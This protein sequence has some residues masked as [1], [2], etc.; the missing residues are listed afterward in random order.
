MS[1]KTW[2]LFVFSMILLAFVLFGQLMDRP[3]PGIASRDW[4][5]DRD[6]GSQAVGAKPEG[7]SKVL[8]VAVSMSSTEF[9]ALQK[10]N[11]SYEKNHPGV[12]ISLQN[13]PANEAYSAIKLAAKSGELSDILLIPNGWVNEFAASGFLS[14]RTGDFFTSQ[15]QADELEPLLS[16]MKWNGYIWGIPK[17]VDP[18]V[19]VWNKTVLSQKGLHGPPNTPQ[20]LLSSLQLFAG[21][22]ETD[23]FVYIDPE[24]PYALISLVWALGGDWPGEGSPSQGDKKGAALAKLL[25][26]YYFPTVK[27]EEKK[28]EKAKEKFLSQSQYRIPNQ[29]DSW[30]ALNQGR[31]AM[32][33][34]R[35]SDYLNHQSAGLG[36]SRLPAVRKEESIKAGWLDGRSFCV[37]AQTD[38]VKEA[39][40]WIKAATSEEDQEGFMTEANILPASIAVHDSLAGKNND[41]LEI[42]LAVKA[43]RV[44][45]ADPLSTPKFTRLQETMR[46]FFEGRISVEEFALAVDE[47]GIGT[48]GNE[49]GITPE[50]APGITAPN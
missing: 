45:P 28:Q 10:M 5:T 38:T 43:G 48:P 24:D 16:Q 46:G 2:L 21:S 49:S 19:L 26:A 3:D 1:G 50:A 39:F 32:M 12:T 22:E 20:E 18:Y 40:D 14:Y 27:K 17:D 23:P 8:K 47:I 33:I 15:N 34:A 37:S 42:S 13:I 7:D 4:Q 6:S 29:A 30:L 31:L 11:Q 9:F 25:E 36:V 44:L 35:A 41:W